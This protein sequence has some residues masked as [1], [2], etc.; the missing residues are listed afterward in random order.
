MSDKKILWLIGLLLIGAGVIGLS[1]IE[2]KPIEQTQSG[3][4]TQI[5]NEESKKIPKKIEQKDNVPD[6]LSINLYTDYSNTLPWISVIDISK[7]PNDKKCIVNELLEQSNGFYYLKYE[8]ETS[9]IF[10]IL[11]NPVLH[12]GEK[13]TRHNIQLARILSDGEVSYTDLGYQGEENETVNIEKQKNDV[14]EFDTS[15]ELYKPVNHIRY[16]KRKNILFTETWHYEESEPIKYE[17]KDALGNTLSILRETLIGDSNYR[18]EHVVYDSEG[19]I[20]K[21]LSIYYE[22]ANIKRLMYYDIQNPEESITIESLFDNGLKVGEKIYNGEYVNTNT[23]DS[24][25]NSEG[26]L[27]LLILNN[28]LD[29]TIQYFKN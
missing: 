6:A 1:L 10:I 20:I 4:N 2:R 16:G 19:N 3:N 21:S 11:Q 18:Q 23:I 13:F 28:T 25:Y 5:V 26:S 15:G 7:I 17:N 29:N 8:P 14:W 12:Q 9:E 27:N 22:G 24:K